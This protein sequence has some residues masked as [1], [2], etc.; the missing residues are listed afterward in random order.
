MKEY[1]N[2]LLDKYLDGS[3]DEKEWDQLKAMIGQDEFDRLINE[4]IDLE[5]RQSP[6]EEETGAD[7]IKDKIFKALEARI[8]Q[9]EEKPLVTI[10]ARSRFRRIMVKTL[11]AASLVLLVGIS[12]LL[13]LN[14]GF[15]SKEKDAPPASG[16]VAAVV[17]GSDK[18]VL[19]LADGS[20]LVLGEENGGDIAEQNGVKIIQLDGGRLSYQGAGASNEVLY[21]TITTPRGGQYQVM[22]PDGS[23]VRLNASS[24][25]RFPTKFVNQV[26]EVYLTGQGYF[27]VAASQTRPFIVKTGTVDVAAMGTRFD[28]MAYPEENELNTTLVKGI[29]KVN[30]QASEVL[31]QPGQQASRVNGE[32]LSVREVNVDEV[33]A[34]T[35]GRFHFAGASVA[36]IMRQIQ[37]W[38]DVDVEYRGD[39]SSVNLSG[40]IS[41]KEHI[42]DLLEALQATGDIAFTL[43]G[44]KLIVLPAG[45]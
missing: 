7:G 26:R 39:V 12:I 14:P 18:A 19:T 2:K 30:E 37:R 38:Y 31:L 11:V 9:L 13:Y 21:N 45:N 8:D 16:T 35:N 24:S 34:W 29:V 17:P 28:I 23:T 32:A 3:I 27:E 44:R 4:S 5:L 41:R 15:T 33:I 6:L 1:F 43:E 36:Y 40:I 20:E 22:L 10:G 42:T 25:L